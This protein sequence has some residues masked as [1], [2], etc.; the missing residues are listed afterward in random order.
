MNLGGCLCA[1]RA[2]V[3]SD[4][5]SS[6]RGRPDPGRG[7]GYGFSLRFAGPCIDKQKRAEDGKKLP[8]AMS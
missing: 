1:A 2:S 4:V 3:V 8:A 5:S 6:C 7:A